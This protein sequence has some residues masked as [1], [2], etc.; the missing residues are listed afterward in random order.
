MRSNQGLFFITIFSA[1]FTLTISI[2]HLAYY[3][4]IFPRVFIVNQ[5]VSNLTLAETETTVQA[6]IPK[7]LPEVTLT[8]NTQNWPVDFNN[9][10]ISYDPATSAKNAFILGRSQGFFPDL[11]IKWRQWFKPVRL[12]LTFTINETALEKIYQT[13]RDG[14]NEDPIAPALIL[15]AGGDV[16]LIPGKNGQSLNQ[17]QL[18]KQIFDQ[19][20]RLDFS[21]ITIPVQPITY[22]YSPEQLTDALATAETIKTGRLILKTPEQSRIIS[23]QELLNLISF[24]GGFDAVKIASLTADLAAEI[25]RPSQNAAFRF[26]S[27]RV[28]EFR[29]ALTGLKLNPDVN[30]QLILFALRAM[31]ENPDEHIVDLVIDQSQ[32]EQTIASVNNLG[33][34]GLLGWG[35]SCYRG[36]IAGRKHNVALAA[37]RI[38]GL[39]VA[40]GETFSF[41]QM[42]GDISQ[43]TGY[44][45][46]Y[47]IKNGRT[48]LGDGGG[49]CQVS[50]TLFRAVLNAGLEIIE[51]HPHSYRV[52]YYEQSSPAGIDATV[53]S[54]SVDFKFKNDTGNHVLIQAVNDSGASR[55][56]FQLYGAADGRRATISN[57]RL[58]DQSAP[59]ED[60][61]LDEPS[62][63]TGQTKQVDWKAWGAKTAFDWVVERN[64]T[65]LH[66]QTFYSS[67]RPWQAVF[68]RGTGGN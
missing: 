14:I 39:L 59:P 51:R 53:Y 3:H 35:E 58:W 34:T 54:P 31:A 33:I 27:G 65:I 56:E 22:E 63:P 57:H 42:V 11:L 32:P 24:N 10:I 19:I 37:G 45:S 43:E 60:L 7:S 66:Q 55:L 67:Y 5:E 17:A 44:P 12:P 50:T 20:G 48:E 40:P 68:L 49:V 41:N 9:L 21:P 29:P 36:S 1:I 2:Y 25:D 61:Y 30:N 13:S 52:G 46:A 38:N 26:N 18:S 62:L 16:T 47:V 15:T 64:G 28:V 23:G 8:Y 4:K 6:L